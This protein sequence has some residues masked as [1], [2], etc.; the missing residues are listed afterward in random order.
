[1][2]YLSIGNVLREGLRQRLRQMLL[3]MAVCT[4][5]IAYLNGFLDASY[6]RTHSFP[7]VTIVCAIFGVPAGVIVFTAVRGLRFTFGR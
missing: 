5:L 4:F 2:I 7:L 6:L 1:M 3:Y